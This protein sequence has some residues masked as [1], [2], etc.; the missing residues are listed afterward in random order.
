VCYLGQNTGHQGIPTNEEADRLTKEGTNEVP[1]N[2]NS[3]MPFSVGKKLNKKQ[4]ELEHQARWAACAG[5]RQSKMLMGYPLSGRANELMAMS[6]LRFRADLV[7]LTGDTTL[8]AHLYDLGHTEWQEC[9]LC[10]HDKED[11]VHIVCDCPVLAC[12]RYRI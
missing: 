7:L 11:S 6:R 10:G 2:P 12:K 9:R 5:C 4:L 3:T 1:R 8:R